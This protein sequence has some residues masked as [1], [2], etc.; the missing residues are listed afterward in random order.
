MFSAQTSR[1]AFVFWSPI[2]CLPRYTFSWPWPYGQVH[3]YLSF[4]R[5]VY[6]PRYFRVPL[7][8][9]AWKCTNGEIRARK[10]FPEKS[11]HLET[12]PFPSTENKWK[13]HVFFLIIDTFWLNLGQNTKESRYTT[14]WPK[15]SI[16]PTNFCRPPLCPREKGAFLRRSVLANFFPGKIRPIRIFP[17]LYS[18]NE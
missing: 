8:A 2:S 14:F 17:Q 18:K 15:I 9:P 11:D 12:C 10:I 4:F 3:S 1:G 7:L 13:T 5:G 16:S 6:P